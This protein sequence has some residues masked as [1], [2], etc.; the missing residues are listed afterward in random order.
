MKRL[1]Y[2]FGT[3]L[4]GTSLIA[5]PAL[6]DSPVRLAVPGITSL[7]TES[8]DGVYQKIL[9]RALEGLEVDVRERFYPYKR[10]MLVFEQGEADCI[11]SFTQILEQRMGEDAV[12]ASF[13]LGKFTY[14]LFTPEGEDPVRHLSQLEG[15][16]VGA[17]IG[18]ETYL[19]EVLEGHDVNV[20][21]SKSDA[22]NLAM[23]EHDRFAAMIAA[24]PDILP[25]VENL[26]YDPEA[27]LLESYDRLTCHNTEANRRFLRKL[28]AELR[29]LKEVGLYRELAGDLYV[30][31]D[32]AAA[33][34]RLND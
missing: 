34:G 13:P 16:S 17:V 11:Y 19:D 14:Y 33:S 7:L 4:V 12:I 24:V 32:A 28:S 2:V 1:V 15:Q 9:H 23:L 5:T 30:E 18:H 29:R 8:Q 10:A 27:P 21:W 6:A 31:F 25:Y 3:L 22:Q 20:I 26:S